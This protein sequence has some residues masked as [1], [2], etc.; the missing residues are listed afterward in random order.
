MWLTGVSHGFL[1]ELVISLHAF[2]IH[3]K[4]ELLCFWQLI[5]FIPLYV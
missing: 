3:T 4:T 1:S 5:F 2:L